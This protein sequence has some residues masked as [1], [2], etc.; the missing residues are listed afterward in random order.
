MEEL[1]PEKRD[2]PIS[3]KIT[4]SEKKRLD[5]YCVDK[6]VDSSKVVRFALN[7]L[8]EGK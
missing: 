3:F 1:K 4:A 2:I 5:E 8:L 6:N 7:K